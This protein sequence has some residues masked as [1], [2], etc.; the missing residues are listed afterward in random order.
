MEAPQHISENVYSWNVTSQNEEKHNWLF[1]R[2]T[3]TLQH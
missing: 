1:F 2:N 3:N